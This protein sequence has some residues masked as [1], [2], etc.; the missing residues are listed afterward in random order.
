MSSIAFNRRT[1]PT[2]GVGVGHVFLKT[3]FVVECGGNTVVV[4]CDGDG[5]KPTA[6][7]PIPVSIFSQTKPTL[8]ICEF[9]VNIIFFVLL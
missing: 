8:C 4:L 5:D 9:N 6:I 3:N 7:P 2:N 1:Q